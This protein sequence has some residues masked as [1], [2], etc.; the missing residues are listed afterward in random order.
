MASGQVYKRAEVH[1]VERELLGEKL[2]PFLKITM[3]DMSFSTL[4]VGGSESPNES[5]V[6]EAAA[7]EFNYIDDLEK[8]I[9]ES[10]NCLAQ[11]T[12]LTN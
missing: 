6:M 11:T 7:Y 1:Y 2:A 12:S 3:T 9:R 5:Y 10:V 8:E 4:R